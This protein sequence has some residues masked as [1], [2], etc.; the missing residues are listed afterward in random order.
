MIFHMSPI[1]RV[2][3]SDSPDDSGKGSRVSPNST[4]SSKTVAKYSAAVRR[5]PAIRSEMLARARLLAAD[6]NYP[7]VEI[8]RK[9]ACQILATPDLSEEV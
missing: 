8:M 5:Q 1:D 2:G 9:I 3:H 6:P 7:S 4:V